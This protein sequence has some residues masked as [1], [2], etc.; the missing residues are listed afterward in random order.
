MGL[1]LQQLYIQEPEIFEVQYEGEEVA[2]I[3]ITEGQQDRGVLEVEVLDL[4][5]GLL[6]KVGAVAVQEV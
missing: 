3:I 4:L 5:L 2:E 6:K 1:L